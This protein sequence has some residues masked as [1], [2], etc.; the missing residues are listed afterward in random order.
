MVDKDQLSVLLH[1]QVQQ[2]SSGHHSLR[3]LLHH[4]C[5]E[6]KHP[7]LNGVNVA[8]DFVELPSQI[9]KLMSSLLLTKFFGG[10]SLEPPW[11]AKI[12]FDIIV[13]LCRFSYIHSGSLT[14]ANLKLN[15]GD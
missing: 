12:S 8:W 15:Q 6:V 9:K 2:R 3:H 1:Q 11:L 7:S 5:G 4:L 14:F 13:F 10:G